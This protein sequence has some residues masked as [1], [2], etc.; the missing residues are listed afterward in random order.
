MVRF[1]KIGGSTPTRLVKSEKD[2]DFP[3]AARWRHKLAL[4]QIITASYKTV[5]R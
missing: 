3:R 5:T 4:L 1:G 2:A